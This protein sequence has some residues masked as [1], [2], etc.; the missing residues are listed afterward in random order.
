[1]L[2]V[3]MVLM[4]VGINFIRTDCSISQEI[5][6]EWDPSSVP[7]VEGT[8]CLPISTIT[9]SSNGLGTKLTV[10]SDL[11]LGGFCER[12]GIQNNTKAM[13]VLPITTDNSPLSNVSTA[14]CDFFNDVSYQ[15]ET[16][17]WL[18]DGSPEWTLWINSKTDDG[19]CRMGFIRWA[20]Q[21]W[22]EKY[23]LRTLV[24]VIL[25]CALLLCL[26][27]CI[28]IFKSRKGNQVRE[29]HQPLL[30]EQNEQTPS[31]DTNS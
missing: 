25:F 20:Q 11:W 23:F 31:Q 2:K 22:F 24:I 28:R 19:D 9:I 29:G 10:V 14:F 13:V 26:C 5:L 4:A 30:Q 6:G 15:I 17:D 3:L 21:S 27:I 8:C 1:M 12:M 16:S 7:S 18:A